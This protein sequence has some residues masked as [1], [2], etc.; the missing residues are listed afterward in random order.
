MVLQAGGPGPEG[1]YTFDCTGDLGIDAD[2]RTLP[3]V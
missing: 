1:I 3:G 2:S